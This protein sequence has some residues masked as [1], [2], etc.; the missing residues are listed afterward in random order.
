MDFQYLV[1][2]NALSALST[3]T[4]ASKFFRAHCHIPEEVLFEAR[5]FPDIGILEECKYETTPGVLRYLIKVM[6][7][8]PVG[9]NSLVDLYANSGNADPFIVA[10]ALDARS[11]DEDKLFGPTW[12][13]VSNDKAVRQKAVE[14][15]IEIRSSEE[16][17]EIICAADVP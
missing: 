5:G 14:F 11:H 4:R 16:F 6:A 1:D 2:N 7:T 13:I 9:D 10:C 8:V 3:S 12:V 17:A 15:K